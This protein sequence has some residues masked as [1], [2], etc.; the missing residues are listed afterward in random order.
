MKIVILFLTLS[1]FCEHIGCRVTNRQIIRKSQ[2]RPKITLADFIFQRLSSKF[3]RKRARKPRIDSR[4]RLFRHHHQPRKIYSEQQVE[5][6]QKLLKGFSEV[7]STNPVYIHSLVQ[8]NNYF[9]D[10]NLQPY[11]SRRSSTK[12]PNYNQSPSRNYVE[13]DSFKS[14]PIDKTPQFF[15]RDS[16][17]SFSYGKETTSITNPVNSDRVL[18]RYYLCSGTACI[19]AD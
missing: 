16:R 12:E 11:P 14:S 4:N 19:P 10:N 8:H 3:G 17:Q 15:A 13:N 1:F 5:N 6:A 9:L 7:S 18:S 2:P